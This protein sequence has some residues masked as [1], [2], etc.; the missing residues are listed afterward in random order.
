[1]PPFTKSPPALIERFSAVLDRTATPAVDRRL[2]F[3]YPCAFVGGN[4]ATGLFA[5]QW[6]VRVPADQL[7][8]MLESGEGRPFEPMPG[9]PMRGYVVLAEEAV[10]DDARI[11][12]WVGRALAFSG[13][14][15]PKERASKRPR[16]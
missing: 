11:D 14:L 12:A 9:R 10:A 7:A 15:P 1:M 4:M 16:R 5:G 6:W 13:T 3:G 2:M 8:E